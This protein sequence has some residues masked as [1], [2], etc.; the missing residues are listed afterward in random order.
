MHGGEAVRSRGRGGRQGWKHHSV[1][2]GGPIEGFRL[3]MVC[4]NLPFEKI[5]GSGG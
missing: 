5:F 4:L 3:G 2:G 1:K